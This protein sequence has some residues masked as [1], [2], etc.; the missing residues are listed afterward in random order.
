MIKWKKKP[1]PNCAQRIKKNRRW[2]ALYSPDI[3]TDADWEKKNGQKW[4]Q[5]ETQTREPNGQ[6]FESSNAFSS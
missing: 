3:K 2:T 5:N 4:K 1:T 6:E